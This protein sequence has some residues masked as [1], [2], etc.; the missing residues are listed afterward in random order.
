M[1]RTHFVSASL[2]VVALTLASCGSSGP[3]TLSEDDFVTQMNA[4]CKTAD[5]ALQKLEGG[6]KSFF[7]DSDDIIQTGLD[8]LGKLKPPKALQ[9]DFDDYVSNLEDIQ[10]QVEKLGKAVED[11]DNDAAQKASDKLEKLNSDNNEVA[12]SIGADRC[13]DVGVDTTATTDTTSVA[14]TEA[15]ATTDAPETTAAP[16][17]TDAPETTGAPETTD[18]PNTPLSIDTTPDTEETTVTTTGGTGGG[19]VA[20]DIS[21]EFQPITGFT[22]G[23][24][25][26]IPGTLTPTDDPVLGPLL[27]AYYIGVMENS[28]DGT[29]VYVY[30]TVLSQNTDWTA[31]QLAAYYNFELVGDGG[32]DQPTPENGLPARV[33]TNAIDGYDGGVFTIPGFGVSVLAPTG[34]DIL[35]LL[36]AFANAQSMGS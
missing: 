23:T 27:D 8:D 13:V 19:V 35:G 1:K 34:A 30:L 2:A 17:T 32:V 12:E 6:D 24:L 3:K 26:D 15:P 10:T 14:T 16:E 33:K 22:W 21:L 4:V 31:D 36:D 29:A 7:S 9:S 5:R 11:E 25:E 20:S 28:T 18:T